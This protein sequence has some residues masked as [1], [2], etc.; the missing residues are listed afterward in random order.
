M[1]WNEPGGNGN[2][3]PWGHK[4]NEQ[5]PPDLD[6]VFQKIQNKMGNIFGNGSNNNSDG[7]NGNNDGGSLSWSAIGFLAVIF[8]LIWSLFGFYIVQPAE[9]GVVTQ[10]GR[11][12]ET[13]EQGLNWH[14]PYPIETVEKVNVEQVRAINH[15][16]LMLTK[17]ENIVVIELVVQYRIKNAENYLFKVDNPEDTLQQATES[18]LREIVGSSKMDDVLTSERTRVALQTKEVIQN[19]IDPYEVGLTVTSVNM[20]NA[21]PPAAV[22]AAFAD[23]IK[24]REDQERSKNKANAYANQVIER[25]KGTADRLIEEAEAYKAQVT[26]QSLGDTQRFLSVLKEYEKA[27]DITRQRLYL[28]T[29]ESVLSKTSKVMVDIKSGNNVMLLPLDKFLDRKPEIDTTPLSNI[30]ESNPSN[31]S[32]KTPTIIRNEDL[33]SR[34]GR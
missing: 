16:A 15:R 13:T 20:Q 29:M 7:G 18:A 11:Y 4:K 23:V 21:Q 3:D 25:A 32:Q 9:L 19:I 14:L 12:K 27:P 5:G 1:A 26:A 2:Q 8:L 28:E 6:E 22:Q 34:G 10:F 31:V 30:T 33:R 17:D 24:A